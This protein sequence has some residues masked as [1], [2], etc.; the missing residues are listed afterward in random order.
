[1]A[2]VQCHDCLG[3]ERAP[4]LHERDSAGT[5]ELAFDQSANKPE[6]KQCN[7]NLQKLWLRLESEKPT[8]SDT[9]PYATRY[10]PR[11]DQYANKA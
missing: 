1:M 10:T 11:M 8:L 9:A 3:K 5:Q 7:Y 6:E 4:N 2:S